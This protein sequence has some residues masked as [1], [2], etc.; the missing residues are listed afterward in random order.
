[1]DT[2]SPFCDKALVYT[3]PQL[4]RTTME[5][6]M[7][8]RTLELN[9]ALYAYLLDVSLRESEVQRAL[10]EVTAS[11]ELARMQIAPEQGQFMAM[12]VKLT[13][14]RNILEIGTFTGYSALSMALAL[15]DEGKVTCCDISEEWTS[16]ALPFWEQAGVSERIDLHIAPALE[17]LD[18]LLAAG[19]KGSFDMAFIDAD[20]ANYRHYFE[21]CLHLVRPNGLILFDNTLWSGRVADGSITDEDTTALRALNL[22]LRDDPRIDLSMLPLGDGLTLARVV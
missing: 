4:P 14:A 3:V 2:P 7:S 12:L 21:R 5:T 17:T 9:D 1:M 22:A 20:K 15:P 18:T 16:I 19:G 8:N 10:R 13:G 6:C 11:H